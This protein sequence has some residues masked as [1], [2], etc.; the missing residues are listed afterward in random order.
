MKKLNKNRPDGFRIVNQNNLFIDFGSVAREKYS[1]NH[2]QSAI[3]YLLINSNGYKL[4][5]STP[6]HIGVIYY[7]LL[8]K[9]LRT[10]KK[11]ITYYLKH[12]GVGLDLYEFQPC[13]TV[14]GLCKLPERGSKQT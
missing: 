8:R 12:F 7:M 13:E 3:F 5:F 10:F 9:Q 2:A 1:K 11:T 14:F 6:P 4:N